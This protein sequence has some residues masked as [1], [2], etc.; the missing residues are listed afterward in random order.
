MSD[1]LTSKEIVEVQDQLRAIHDK[2]HQ[3]DKQFSGYSEIISAA[4]HVTDATWKL[5]RLLERAVFIE[6][7]RK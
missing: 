5:D 3:W 4:C 6:G 1:F 7:K 2:L